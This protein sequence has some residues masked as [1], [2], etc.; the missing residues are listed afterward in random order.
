M[1]SQLIAPQAFISPL[2]IA[3]A[4]RNALAV[5]SPRQLTGFHRLVRHII[6]RRE[7]QA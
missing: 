6:D 2:V 3:D 5:L 7:P 4:V 1:T